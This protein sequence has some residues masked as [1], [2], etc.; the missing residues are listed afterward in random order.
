MTDNAARVYA[1]LTPHNRAKVDTFIRK[2]LA[3]QQHAP[4]GAA[5]GNGTGGKA[6]SV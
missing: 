1:T 4:P 6:V 5:K 3:E 2:L